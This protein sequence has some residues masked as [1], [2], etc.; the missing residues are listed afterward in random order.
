MRLHIRVVAEQYAWN[1]HYPGRDKIFGKSSIEQMNGDNPLGLD[2]D[3]PKGKDDITTINQ[4]HVP[5]GVPIVVERS[6]R[7]T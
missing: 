4:L 7:K 3:D 2:P 5:L 6:A 1:I